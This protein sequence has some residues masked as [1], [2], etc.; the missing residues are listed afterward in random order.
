MT[1]KE[2]AIDLIE[3]F[4]D[5]ADYQECDIFTQRERLR[6][7]AKYCALIAVDEMIKQQKEQSDNMRWSCITY[8]EEVKY[9]IKKL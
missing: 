7:N 5:F 1:A 8:W 2:K 6:S 4:E 3:K 9:E